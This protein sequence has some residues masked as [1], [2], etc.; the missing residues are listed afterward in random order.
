MIRAYRAMVVASGR[1][2][3]AQIGIWGR[4]I[5]RR[6]AE[7]A[8]LAPTNDLNLNRKTSISP[9]NP[10]NYRLTALSFIFHYIIKV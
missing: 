7:K 1:T 3:G 9:L 4:L 6:G 2:H 5:F 10:R 8:A